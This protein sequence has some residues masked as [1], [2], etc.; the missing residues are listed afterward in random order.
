MLDISPRQL[1]SWVAHGFIAEA[2]SYGFDDLVALKTVKKLR[3]FHI[4]PA[5]IKMAIKSLKLKLDDIDR[6]LAQLRIV[7]EGKAIAV[8]IGGRKMDS[9]TGQ[10]LF[11]FDKKEI[12][13]LRSFPVKV[14]VPDPSIEEA[15]LAESEQWFQ[16]GLALEEAGAQP[17][18]ALVAY[19][20]AITLNPKASGA[21]VNLG[22]IS[23]RMKKYPDAKIFYRRAIESDPDY[24]LA[25][26]N[27]GNLHDEQGESEEARKHYLEALRLNPRYA[28]AYFNLALLAERTGETLKAIGYWQKYLALDTTTSWAASARKQL[29]RLKRS[30]RTK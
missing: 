16:R 28:D 30:V 20:R 5:Q 6:P 15:K 4:P 13:K 24:P 23:F 12:E 11:D 21:L 10:L 29:N 7:A 27:L 9:I 1:K 22:T 2:E 17:H 14:V 19:K 25:H 3:Q 8:H 18:E 26:F